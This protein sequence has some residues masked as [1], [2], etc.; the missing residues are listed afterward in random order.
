MQGGLGSKLLI[1]QQYV[2]YGQRG[3]T[4]A[5]RKSRP[6]EANEKEVS[7]QNPGVYFPIEGAILG[8]RDVQIVLLGSQGSSALTDTDIEE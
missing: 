3:T 2:S 7:R 8:T 5:I 6:D 1:Q 4:R